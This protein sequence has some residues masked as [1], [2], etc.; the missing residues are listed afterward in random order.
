MNLLKNKPAFPFETI[1]VALAFSPRVKAMLK[2]AGRM[3]ALYESSLIVI[4]IGK[5]S[6]E[7]ER[8][9]T[10][11]LTELNLDKTKVIWREGSVAEEV[12]STCKKESVDLLLLGAL[13]KESMFKFYV[14]SIARKISRKAKCSILLFT[15][16][17]LNPS[18]FKRIVVSGVEH[19]KTIETIAT[20]VY[21]ARKEAAEELYLLKE[22]ESPT[23]GLHLSDDKTNDEI[24]AGKRKYKLDADERCKKLIEAIPEAAEVNIKS[25]VVFGQ[26][27]HCIKNFAKTKK[28]DLMVINS[29][30]KSLGLMDRVFRHD[31]EHLLAELPCNLLIVHSRGQN[32]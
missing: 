5:K 1:A 30:D 10:D 29:P 31:M 22:E 23:L 12:L 7:S 24:E 15:E 26:P 3:A 19:P 28:S 11:L 17:K 9:M 2:E 8:K 16:P 13:I 21:L 18:P 4:H 32:K 20:A 27:G 14:G 6:S 25:R